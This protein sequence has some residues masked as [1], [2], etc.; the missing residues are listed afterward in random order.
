M[1][2]RDHRLS[3]CII[4]AFLATACGSQSKSAPSAETGASRPADW[5]EFAG[6]HDPIDPKD[7]RLVPERPVEITGVPY[8][9]AVRLAWSSANEV[10]SYEPQN[11]TLKLP[12]ETKQ[13]VVAVVVKD[14]PPEADL[15]VDW[16]FGDEKVFSDTLGSRDDGDH[17][18]ALVKRL[19]RGL[20]TLPPGSYRADVFDRS[21]L[22]KSVRFEIA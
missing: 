17:Y 14:L 12:A 15:R 6:S 1:R 5:S 9:R 19:A 11:E 13:A 2:F 7:A 21:T 22:V 18:F 3:V 10:P 8:V 20:A 4:A 16:Y